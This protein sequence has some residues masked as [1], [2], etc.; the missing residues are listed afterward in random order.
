MYSE[1]SKLRNRKSLSR[2]TI[3]GKVQ[4][5]LQ[6]I[7]RTY[8]M[9]VMDSIKYMYIRILNNQTD[10]LS[11]N[12]MPPRL[13]Y[14]PPIQSRYGHPTRRLNELIWLPRNAI[15]VGPFWLVI[16]AIII[17]KINES[18]WK[19]TRHPTRPSHTLSGKSIG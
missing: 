3:V 14:H 7:W 4:S 2:S 9:I 19:A 13:S 12:L 15:K 10:N 11:A 6:F 16:T 17:F 1:V 18:S 8:D 5:R